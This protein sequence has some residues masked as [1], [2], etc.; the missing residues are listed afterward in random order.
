MLGTGRYQLMVFYAGGCPRDE[1][2]STILPI[3]AE[4]HTVKHCRSEHWV[5]HNINRL[6]HEVWAKAGGKSYDE[7]VTN[8]AR[9]ILTKHQPKALP[10]KV[11]ESL[12]VIYQEA[13]KHLVTKN[14]AA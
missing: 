7:V 6:T 1:M 5:F 4:M 13:E 8:K 10:E 11:V 9:D 12:T 14:L 3:L 2:L